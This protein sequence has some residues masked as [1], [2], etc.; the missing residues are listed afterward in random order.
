MNED[1]LYKLY[2]RKFGQVKTGHKLVP[3]DF[4]STTFEG[5]EPYGL[6]GQTAVT[7]AASDA[8]VGPHPRPRTEFV[9][10]L[11]RLLA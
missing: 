9:A 5:F 1:E 4:G 2:V 7:L 8:Q 10:E 3:G 11:K 6:E